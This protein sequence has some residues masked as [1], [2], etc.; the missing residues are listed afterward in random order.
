MLTGITGRAGALVDCISSVTC[1]WM[2][3]SNAPGGHYIYSIQANVG[4]WGG[5]VRGSSCNRWEPGLGV[6][7]QVTNGLHFKSGDVLD[8]VGFLCTE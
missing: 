1:K 2:P 4:G 5:T 7:D 8:A 3:D 6:I